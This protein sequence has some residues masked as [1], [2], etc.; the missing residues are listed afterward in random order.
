MPSSMHALQKDSVGLE[1]M[2][3]SWYLVSNSGQGR[4]SSRLLVVLVVVA[5]STWRY[6]VGLLRTIVPSG[7]TCERVVYCTTALCKK[8]GN[9]KSCAREKK[10]KCVCLFEQQQQ[11]SLL[12]K[13]Y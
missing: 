8:P 5:S 4:R 10:K 7:N 3:G 6:D 12:D 11:P 9:R 1:K 13:S 2:S